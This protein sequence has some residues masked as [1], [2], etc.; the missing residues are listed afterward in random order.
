MKTIPVNKLT[1]GAAVFAAVAFI[2]IGAASSASEPK[3][4]TKTVTEYKTKEVKGE[5]KYELSPIC[6]EA[7]VAATQNTTD[8]NDL[9]GQIGEGIVEFSE[10][11][12]TT[13]IENAL[14]QQEAVI[15]DMLEAFKKTLACDSSI[16]QD[17]T[18]AE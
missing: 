11:Y 9:V 1:I 6:R 2:G 16:G 3:T 8:F 14:V 10:T 4:E 17:V 13:A 7:L 5:T 15:A 18:I 12:E